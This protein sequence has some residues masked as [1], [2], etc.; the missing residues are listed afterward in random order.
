M[1]GLR[2]EEVAALAGVS[3]DYY[4]HIEQGRETSPSDQV[5]GSIARALRLSDHETDYLLDLVAGQ[6]VVTQIPLDVAIESLIGRWPLS[7]A[8]VYDETLTIV[9]T[10]SMADELSPLFRP[11]GNALR[12][13]FLE[14]QMRDFY[15]NW[16]GVTEWAVRWVRGHVAREPSSGLLR[17]IDELITQS[18]RFRQ[19]WER[20]SVQRSSNGLVLLNHPLVGRL[21]L[22]FQHMVVPATNHVLVVYWASPNSQ[23]D[24][25]MERL[26]A[27]HWRK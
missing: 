4:V 16:D 27:R 1:P 15:C 17:L 19:L 3:T 7:A 13:L 8:Q 18:P 24:E 10:N 23:S 25:R 5:L 6:R 26:R 9:A 21:E 20:Q 12:A 2:R 22:H 14:P 11:G